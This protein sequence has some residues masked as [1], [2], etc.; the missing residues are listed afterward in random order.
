[1]AD[2]D[3]LD[4]LYDYFRKHPEEMLEQNIGNETEMTECPNC[5]KTK[6]VVLIISKSR[7]KCKNCNMEFNLSDVKLNL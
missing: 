1:M 3:G 4:E 5:K 6:S 7:I 2:F